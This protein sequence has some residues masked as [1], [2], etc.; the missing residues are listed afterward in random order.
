MQNIINIGRKDFRLPI[1]I[2]SYWGSRLH[3]DLYRLC[4]AVC[5]GIFH[6]AKSAIDVGSYIG[7]LI[8][9]LD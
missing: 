5:R 7:R 8:C 1:D 4:V 3:H 9:E 6:D 2:N